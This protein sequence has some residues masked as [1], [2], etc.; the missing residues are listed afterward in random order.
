MK[1]LI[2]V[3]ATPSWL[4][5]VR[6]AVTRPWPA[7]TKFCMFHA[8]DP[9]H[10]VKAPLLLARA[11]G[12]AQIQL[13]SAAESLQHAGWSA[14]TEVLLGNP[15]KAISSFAQEWGADLILAGS[16]GHGDLARILLGSTSK[17]VLRSAPCSVEIV[18][19]PAKGQERKADE[20][21]R[22]LAA[23]DGSDCSMG[24]VRS[25]AERPWPKG[26]EV[27]VIS[28]P[29]LIIPLR[30]FPYFEPGEVE[31]IN[32]F[33]LEHAREAAT[34]ANELLGKSEL[35]SCTEV[36]LEWDIPSRMILAEAEKWRAHM[37]VLGSH[38]R[39]GFD[40]WTMGSVSE[41]VAL[42]AGCSVEVIR[43]AS[44]EKEKEKKGA[45]S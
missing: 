31:E 10:F 19:S 12:A 35:K 17:A 7:G 42:N 21:M 6:E 2:A 3:D 37:I 40:R 44:E 36:P 13:K 34:K 1:V 16:H 26:S 28:I 25:V 29:E 39:R 27:K 32:T 20:G 18:R 41:A 5:V 33:S 38:G 14:E 8:V 15:R 22:I 23:T 43:E 4:A 45:K 24:A 30:E 9:F 11:K